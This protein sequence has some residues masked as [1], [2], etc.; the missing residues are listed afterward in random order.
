MGKGA[1][2]GRRRAGVDPLLGLVRIARS[3]RRRLGS[4]GAWARR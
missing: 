3:R 1:F 4:L 2:T